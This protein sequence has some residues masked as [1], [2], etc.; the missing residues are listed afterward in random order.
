MEAVF[1]PSKRLIS[2]RDL[3]QRHMSRSKA[4]LARHG[5][6]Y[7]HISSI[8]FSVSACVNVSKTFYF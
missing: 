6:P 8:C 4:I 7:D 2:Q 1:L 3:H 5:Y